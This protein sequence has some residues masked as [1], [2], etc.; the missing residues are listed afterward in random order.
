[1]KVLHLTTDSE[2]AGAERL[3]ALTAQHVS[4]PGCEHL[5][6][7][8]RTRG[9]LHQVIES[10]GGRALS[11]DL[12]RGNQMG[13]AVRRLLWLIRKE[14]VDLIHTHLFH[15]GVLAWIA[16]HCAPMPVWVHTRHYDSWLHRHGKRW[17]V[18]LDQYAT[19]AANEVVAISRAVRN[20]LV[21]VDRV[22][23]DRIEVIYNGIHPPESQ[24]ALP[25][26]HAAPFLV[27]IGTLSVWKGHQHLVAAMPLIRERIPGARLLI[28][29]EGTERPMLQ[30]LVK[31]LR[32]D[33]TVELPG[34]AD[35]VFSTLAKA[36]LMVHPS[37]EEGFGIALLEGMSQ[38]CAVVATRVGGIPE[39][40]ED[41]VTGLLVPSADPERLAT[42][43]TALLCD[44]S[45]RQEMGAAGRRRLERHFTVAA[46]LKHYA[47]LYERMLDSAG[48]EHRKAA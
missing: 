4:T 29:G 42:A 3:L 36:D 38:E 26:G 27:A 22:P 35:S 47:E 14:R 2:I 48:A 8:L 21:E 39:V 37:L 28:L 44:S 45:R 19:R 41:G 1:V 40:V 30:R 31:T 46:M 18:L 11:L 5:F 20:V 15:A 16:S 32:L 23:A 43:V 24:R 9:P 6:C 17:E 12:H 25:R 33:G 13:I 10:A 7:T 34:R